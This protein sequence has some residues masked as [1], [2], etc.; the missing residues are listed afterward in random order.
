MRFHPKRRASIDQRPGPNIARAAPAVPNNSHTHRSPDSMTIFQSSMKAIETP[1]IGVH[2]P[3]IKR[4]P[5]PIEST[6]GITIF[7]PGSGQSLEIAR[8]ISADPTTSRIRSKPEPGQPPA[9]VEYKRRN[10]APSDIPRISGF[11]YYGYP[12]KG[13]NRHSLGF[14]SDL[15][16]SAFLPRG[17]GKLVKITVL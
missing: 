9:N 14:L 17:G 7:K 16:E 13:R 15:W 2:K 10:R 1:T 6:A 12:Q 11:A 5:A 8:T 4:I 3:T